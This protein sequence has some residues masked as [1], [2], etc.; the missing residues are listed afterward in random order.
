M[1]PN[2]LLF[3]LLLS[4]LAVSGCRT[5]NYRVVEPVG[6]AGTISDQPVT[7]RYE[8]LEYR[9]ARH[10]ERLSLRIVNPTDDRLVLRGDRSFVIDPKGESHRVQ[11]RVIG[12]HMV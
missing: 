9:L 6:L 7:I 8:P 4:I 10:K 1:T 12:P 5:S 2:F 11:G 3:L